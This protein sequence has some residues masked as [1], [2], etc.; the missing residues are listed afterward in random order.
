MLIV[1]PQDSDSFDDSSTPSDSVD[2]HGRRHAP[3]Y[4]EDASD[5]DTSMSDVE[6]DNGGYISQPSEDPR[7]IALEEKYVED[8]R[9]ATKKSKGVTP[10]SLGPDDDW[11]GVNK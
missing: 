5:D 7:V 6:V 8:H 9:R 1:F 10:S 2:G 3:E 4:R 11:L